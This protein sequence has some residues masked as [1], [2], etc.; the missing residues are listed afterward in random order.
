VCKGRHVRIPHSKIIPTRER[1]QKGYV[2]RRMSIAHHMLPAIA[3]TGCV[4]EAVG[5]WA[6]NRMTN[7]EPRE[8]PCENPGLYTL[9]SLND[10]DKF[11]VATDILGDGH[12]Y[13]I[14]LELQVMEGN[15]TAVQPPQWQCPGEVY[16]DDHCLVSAV[17]I[18]QCGIRAEQNNEGIWCKLGQ[19][20]RKLLIIG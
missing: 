13:I 17:C 6:D 19:I 16:Y 1:M 3:A 15:K 7:I 4:F 18:R 10:C 14:I 8:G 20:A 12:V 2:T 5:D 11:G 9:A